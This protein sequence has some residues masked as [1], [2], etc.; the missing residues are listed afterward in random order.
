MR[1]ELNL[2]KV[3]LHVCVTS[4]PTCVTVLWGR[5]TKLTV[6]S[7]SRFGPWPVLSLAAQHGSGAGPREPYPNPASLLHVLSTAHGHATSHVAKHRL[8]TGSDLL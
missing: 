7:V 5:V 4:H 1:Y 2:P 3:P 8:L 6:A